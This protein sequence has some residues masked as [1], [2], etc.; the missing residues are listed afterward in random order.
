MLFKR[1]KYLNNI[2]PFYEAN[3]IIKVITGVRRCGKSSLMMTIKE[4]L[5]LKGIDEKNIIYIDLD[6]IEY[7]KIKDVEKLKQVID[8]F[9]ITSGTTYLF[10]DEIQNIDNFEP[11]INA[12]RATNKY[13]IFITGS[14]SYLLSGELITK[15]TGRYLEFELFPLSFDEYVEMKKFYDKKVD[16]NNVVE[17]NSYILDGGFPRT[18]FLE[19]KNAKELY[20]RGIIK[21][22]FEKDIKRRV[23]IR[24]VESFEIVKN[25]VI[26]NFGSIITINS[27]QKSLK[28]NDISISRETI[29]RYI[30]ILA[31]AKIIYEC[32]RFDIKSKK[33]MSNEK[34]FF[35]ADLGFYFSNS[36]N[37]IINYGPCLENI[38]FIYAKSMGYDISIGKI[39]NLECDFILRDINMNYSYVQVAYT[40]FNSKETDDREYKAL[41]NIKDN[42]PK[43]VMTTDY[44]LQRRNGIKHV[45]IMDFIIN[46][47]RFI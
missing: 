30:D 5:L 13:S 29:K 20:L 39:G 6:S 41:E 14:N 43:Y 34:K 24:D 23:K 40:I 45:N 38:I 18:L 16:S 8:S 28:K 47:E 12:Y 22:I 31:D 1:E 46:K 44:L 3:D 37:N 2:R 36:T 42:Y 17:L 11:L 10:I 35:L 32:K 9:N 7:I 26:S 33:S 19:D 25:F 21:E 27:I 4:E 15:L